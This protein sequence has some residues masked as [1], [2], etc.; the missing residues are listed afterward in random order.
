MNKKCWIGSLPV[1]ALVPVAGS[2]RPA[3]WRR[4][5]RQPVARQFCQKK[6]NRPPTGPVDNGTGKIGSGGGSFCG[7]DEGASANQVKNL[8]QVNVHLYLLPPPPPGGRVEEGAALASEA[9]DVAV[10]WRQEACRVPC[11]AEADVDI[12]VAQEAQ[13]SD[14]NEQLV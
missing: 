3:R 9:L 14:V 10:C 6:C 7:A 12:H 13:V 2:S 1:G 8:Q 11:A 5:T 4:P